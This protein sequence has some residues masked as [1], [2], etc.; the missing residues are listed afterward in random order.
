MVQRDALKA[1]RDELADL[2][3]CSLDVMYESG[4]LPPFYGG[5]YLEDAREVI[6]MWSYGGARDEPSLAMLVVRMVESA[7]P[8]ADLRELRASL[9]LENDLAIGDVLMTLFGERSRSIGGVERVADLSAFMIFAAD[10]LRPAPGYEQSEMLNHI[11]RLQPFALFPVVPVTGSGEQLVYQWNDVEHLRAEVIYADSP[12]MLEAAVW[13]YRLRLALE[14]E[15]SALPE[16]VPWPPD[17]LSAVTVHELAGLYDLLVRGA[18]RLYGSTSP[19]RAQQERLD[20]LREE[21]GDLLVPMPLNPDVEPVSVLAAERTRMKGDPGGVLLHI[22]GESRPL[23]TYWPQIRA[24]RYFCIRLRG[25]EP[26]LG[27][28][29]TTDPEPGPVL[30]WLMADE[31]PQLHRLVH[32][33]SLHELL[34][35]SG[36]LR[37]AADSADVFPAGMPADG[38]LP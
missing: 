28:A 3:L 29:C 8:D 26:N 7:E 31:L 6:P 23:L 11:A 20:V 38:G 22:S 17:A 14:R 35:C 4:V 21:N 30:E 2:H 32:L 33:F 36:L 24:S 37:P 9:G 19:L 1:L 13:D 5:E 10:Q 27:A 34:T 12:Q 16:D 25:A 18:I 15:M